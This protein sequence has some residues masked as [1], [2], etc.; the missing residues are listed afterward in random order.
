MFSLIMADVGN[1]SIK[2]ALSD[3]RRIDQPLVMRLGTSGFSKCFGMFLR[4]NREKVLVVSSVNRKGLRA[5]ESAAR[6][7]AM[8]PLVLAGRELPIPIRNLTAK[9]RQVGA[10]RLLAALA[11]WKRAKKCCIVVDAGSAITVDLVD[12]EGAFLGGAILPG[13]GL[14]ASVLN[15]KTDLLPLVLPGAPRGEVGKTTEEA[16][17]LGLWASTAGACRVIVERYRQFLG[18]KAPVFLTGADARRIA[19]AIEGPK[20]IRPFLVLEGLAISAREGCARP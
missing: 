15:E 12:D 14:A 3:G 10:D 8:H 7:A 4:R 2:L 17:R 11:A 9:P 13:M 16:I 5:L 1:T 6:K 19:P 20:K 18:C